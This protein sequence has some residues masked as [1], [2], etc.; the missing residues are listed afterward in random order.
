MNK[1]IKIIVSG[2]IAI[3]MSYVVFFT[4]EIVVYAHSSSWEKWKEYTW[5][6]K[7]AEKY[8]EIGHS[9]IRKRSV[10]SII[11]YKKDYRITIWEFKDL[12][13]IDLDNIFYNE[14]LTLDEVNIRSGEVFN[15]KGKSRVKVKYGYSFNKRFKLHIDKRSEIHKRFEG[16]NYK[17]FSADIYKMSFSN[18]CGEHQILFDYQEKI[19][20]VVVLYKAR[21]SFY[22]IIIDS[23]SPNYP[24][25]WTAINYLSL[26]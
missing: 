3:V 2:A 9:N 20:S 25:H 15:P 7:D 23:S 24:I 5:L 14:K 1:I 22:V 18:R 4:Y 6:I 21:G 17:G 13:E 19:P 26:E 11:R 8:V 10:R 16:T 12:G